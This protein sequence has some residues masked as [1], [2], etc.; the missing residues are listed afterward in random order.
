MNWYEKLE[1]IRKFVKDEKI[2]NEMTSYF[3]SDDL[4]DFVE[5]LID[6]YDLDDIVR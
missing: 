2:I 1:K 5:H 4:E 6:S 3:S